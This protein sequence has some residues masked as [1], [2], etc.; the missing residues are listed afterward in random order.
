[1]KTNQF[2]A[3]GVVSAVLFSG[4]SCSTTE[5]ETPAKG[6]SPSQSD[7]FGPRTSNS[8]F[9]QPNS[10]TDPS[11]M[12][13]T[14]K[15]KKPASGQ[16]PNEETEISAEMDAELLNEELSNSEKSGGSV[17]DGADESLAP[18]L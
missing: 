18:E 14:V 3:I 1:M 13:T 17:I 6:R 12:S 4:L 16:L 11:A 2:F 10:L 5:E 8:E 9:G 7:E 15:K